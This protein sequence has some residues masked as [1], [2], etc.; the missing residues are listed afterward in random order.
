MTCF[1][2]SAI[3][4]CDTAFPLA[5]EALCA[6]SITPVAGATRGTA[7]ADLRRR[8]AT[9]ASPPFKSLTRYGD[10]RCLASASVERRRLV[11]LGNAKE[12]SRDDHAV[13]LPDAI[14]QF[15]RGD[16]SEDEGLS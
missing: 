16:I 14:D 13:P 5:A 2:G 4:L 3:W 15:Q 9:A 11:A 8:F 12:D 1:S 10:P 7:A 6:A